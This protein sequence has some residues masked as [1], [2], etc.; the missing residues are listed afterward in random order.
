MSARDRAL[1][2]LLESKDWDEIIHSHSK[3]SI[4]SA[5]D[6]YF[7]TA[8]KEYA[9]S[10][11]KREKIKNAR[12]TRKRVEVSPLKQWANARLLASSSLRKVLLQENDNLPVEEFLAKMD[13]WLKMCQF[14]DV[15]KALRERAVPKL[16]RRTCG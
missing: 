4:Y 2:D 1:K 7:K 15:S 13:I 12:A 6:E 9:E 11:S 8:K 16:T 3:S 5:L 14:E 10:C